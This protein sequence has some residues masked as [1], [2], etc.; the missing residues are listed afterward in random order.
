[1][2]LVNV[3]GTFGLRLREAR[4]AAGLTQTDLAALVEVTQTTI[5]CWELGETEPNIVKIRRLAR[6]LKITVGYLLDAE[7]KAA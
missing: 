3:N 5:S 1:M 2:Y 6:V 7:E 4:R